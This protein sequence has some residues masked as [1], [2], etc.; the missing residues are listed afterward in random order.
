MDW[1]GALR[2]RLLADSPLDTLVANRIYIDAWMLC[3]VRR[4]VDCARRIP[5]SYWAVFA[6]SVTLSAPIR[7]V[8]G[9]YPSGV[10]A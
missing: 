10:S 5:A 8:T 7:A 2:A 1:R 4:A 9:L 6:P 3:P